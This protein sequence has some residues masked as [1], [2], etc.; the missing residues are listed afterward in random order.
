MLTP[1]PGQENFYDASLRSETSQEYVAATSRDVSQKRNPTLGMRLHVRGFRL[2]VVEAMSEVMTREAY[3]QSSG[4]DEDCDLFIN[5]IESALLL[6]KSLQSPR[7]SDSDL[8]QAFCLTIAAGFDK[9][10]RA[11]SQNMEKHISNFASFCRSK[12]SS[13]L[14]TELEQCSI[15][16]QTVDGDGRNFSAQAR[17]FCHGRR[18]FVTDDGLFG[19]GPTAMEKDDICC[20][21]IGARVPFLLRRAANSELYKVVGECYLHGYMEG[22]AIHDWRKGALTVED[23]V[24]S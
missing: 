20:V 14:N 6:A 2:A 24:L 1:F 11:A 17:Q 7:Q 18:F 3:D 21:L 13:R 5:P 10:R 19:L 23:V 22:K 4:L 15:M 8:L 16:Q 12:F 9:L